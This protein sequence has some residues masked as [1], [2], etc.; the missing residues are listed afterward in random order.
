MNEPVVDPVFGT[1]RQVTGRVSPTMLMSM[2]AEDVFWDGRARSAFPDPLNPADIVIPVGGALESQAVGPILSNVEMAHDGR[3]WA[4]VTHKLAVATPLTRAANI[5]PD[6]AAALV[7]NP[8]YPGLFDAAFGDPAITPARIGMAIATYERTLV[9]DQTPW[10]LYMAGDTNALTPDQVQGWTDF[11]E[12]TICDNCHRVSEFTDHQFYNIGLRPA[13]EDIGRQDVTQLG[14]D[15]GRFK[16][17]SLR[18]VGLRKALM[19]VGWVTDSQDAAD[20]YKAESA[21]TGHTQFTQDQSSIPTQIPGNFVDYSTLS[22]FVPSAAR[23]AAVIDFLE[24]GLT[25]PR[26]AAEQFPFDRPVLGSEIA[27]IMT[28]NVQARG[29][30]VA[31]ADIV[32]DIIRQQDA[33][34]VG[35][36]EAGTIQQA[37]LLA[38]LGDVYDFENFAG[39]AAF[40]PIL[41]K[42]NVFSILASGSNIVAPD[43]NSQGFVNYLVLQHI[44][45]AERLIVHNAHFCAT[46]AT[47]PPGEP[48]A[49]E[50]NQA[51]AVAVVDAIVANQAAWNAPFIVLGDLNASINSDTMQYLLEQTPLPNG[52]TN[53]I[54]LNDAWD[55]AIPGVP[56][57]ARINWILMTNAGFTVLDAAVISDAQTAQASDNEPVLTTLAIDTTALAPIVGTDNEPPGVP[58]NLAAS[59]I[60]ATSV[61]LNWAAATDNVAV[62]GYRVY[63]DG[64]L[65]FASASL[66]FGDSGLQAATTYLYS[67][68]AQDAGGNESLASEITVTTPAAPV[69]T[70]PQAT[71]GGSAGAWLLMLLGG[72]YVC[73]KRRRQRQG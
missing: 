37:D 69:T 14:E 5:P 1:D 67:V 22:F 50:R 53:S 40:E 17:P 56:Y 20:F 46:I 57:P 72:T 61:S 4:D 62:T 73:R 24:N 9:P 68:T 29:W 45:S 42:K 48:T 19:H 71:S 44:G 35:L 33:D 6:M 55:T 3:T 49:T 21:N 28:Y 52:A 11:S 12:Q 15:F 65:L 2:Y 32:A 27:T 25:D 59:N 34:I 60:T 13:D 8:T 7:D 10:D 47:F 70:V 54:V 51:H 26:V 36:Q 63:R 66:N 18:N 39:G 31:R 16:T 41:L 23:Q 38:R 64:I 30:T 43:C 58:G